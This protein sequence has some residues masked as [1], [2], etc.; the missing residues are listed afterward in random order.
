MWQ[1]VMKAWHTLQSGIEQQDPNTWSKILRQPILGNRFLTN[2]VGTQWGTEPRSNM[3]LWME[4]QIK[5]LKDIIKDDGSAWRTV[6]EQPALTRCPTTPNLY[7]RFLA[8]I[9]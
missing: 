4:K 5:A 2:E 7:A 1:G 3:Q 8:S 6:V 9:P